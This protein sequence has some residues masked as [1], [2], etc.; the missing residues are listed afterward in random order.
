MTIA[1][2]LFAVSALSIAGLALPDRGA[3]KVASRDGYV[4]VDTCRTCHSDQYA[5]WRES[6]H[7]RG[8]SEPGLVGAGE[9][10]AGLEEGEHGWVVAANALHWDEEGEPQPVPIAGN[11]ELARRHWPRAGASFE[12]DCADCH[13]LDWSAQERAAQALEV[14][15]ESCH[16][17]GAAHADWGMAQMMGRDLDDPANTKRWDRQLFGAD[18]A[19]WAADPKTGSPPPRDV[20]NARVQV[21]TCLRCHASNRGWLVDRVHAEHEWSDAVSPSLSAIVEGSET[22]NG[23]GMEY[24]RGSA[25][26][27]AL[28]LDSIAAFATSPMHAGGVACTDCHNQHTGEVYAADDLLC[29]RC[30]QGASFDSAAH[31]HH[32]RDVAPACIDC[33]MPVGP[34]GTRD[35][36]LRPPGDA[37]GTWL[38]QSNGCTT[39]HPTWSPDETAKQIA[40]WRDTP[41]APRPEHALLA[42]DPGAWNAVA[43]N[44]ALPATLRAVAALRFARTA[45]P[46][47]LSGLLASP[48]PLVRIGTL[49]G[50]ADRDA[51]ALTKLATQLTTL[52]QDDFRAVRV[53][54]GRL[55]ASLTPEQRAT[56]F[57]EHAD[58]AHRAVGGSR[59]VR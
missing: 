52:A 12:Q 30:H 20:P 36:H 49:R 10:S 35:H 23:A 48:D 50:L 22:A 44:E 6:D 14:S 17:G 57:G 59:S 34:G 3:P 56:V 24:L 47:A 2:T 8:L 32:E 45:E 37:L 26:A 53:E 11:A 5:M 55:A 40:T 18:Y 46:A 16:G 4:R 31:H 27:E 54:L 39:C 33:H 41:R 28:D 25:R 15:C 19:S 51:A 58:A 38:G 29:L 43:A 7:R 21:E 42:D 1:R 9:W 13:L